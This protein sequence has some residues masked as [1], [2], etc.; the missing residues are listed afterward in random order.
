M[1]N[2][3]KESD[4][5][6]KRINSIGVDDQEGEKSREYQRPHRQHQLNQ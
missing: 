1:E 3:I 5:L 6:L 2:A 4:E